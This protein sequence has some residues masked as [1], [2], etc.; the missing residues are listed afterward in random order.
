MAQLWVRTFAGEWVR[1]D[2]IAE[3]GTEQIPSDDTRVDSTENSPEVAVVVRMSS[4]VGRWSWEHDRGS[5]ELHPATHTVARYTSRDTATDV[6][7]RLVVVLLSASK[8][9]QVI[10]DGNGISVNPA[11]DWAEPYWNGES[12]EVC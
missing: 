6:A 2:R 10:V 9:A 8:D 4:S 3:V 5:G 1:A 12:P 11:H 7:R